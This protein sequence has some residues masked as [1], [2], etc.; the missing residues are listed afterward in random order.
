M[1]RRLMLRI[2]VLSIRSVGASYYPTMQLDHLA[3]DEVTFPSG[4]PLK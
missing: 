1:L 3:D 4:L 2:E